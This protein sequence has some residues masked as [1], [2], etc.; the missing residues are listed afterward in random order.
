MEEPVLKTK[1]TIKN[2]TLSEVEAL[3][4]S[5]IEPF[6]MINAKHCNGL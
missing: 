2:F 4:S 1:R 6:N 3:K 5:V